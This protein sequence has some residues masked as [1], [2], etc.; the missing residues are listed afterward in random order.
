[1][2][3]TFWRYFFPDEDEDQDAIEAMIMRVEP[4]SPPSLHDVMIDDT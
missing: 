2:W 4:E 1:M 3:A